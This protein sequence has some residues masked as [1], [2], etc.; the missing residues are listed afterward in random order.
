V[1]YYTTAGTFVTSDDA[2]V[3]ISP[4]HPGH[5]SAFQIL[6]PWQET[7]AQMRITFTTFHGAPIVVHEALPET[8]TAKKKP[9]TAS[10]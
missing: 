8:P 10:R 3:T 1:S 4:L 6:T 2:L 9:Q 5:R 7:I